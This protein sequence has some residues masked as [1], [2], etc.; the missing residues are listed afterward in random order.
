MRII[1]KRMQYFAS[2][3]G[4]YR[5]S[6]TSPWACQHRRRKKLTYFYISS[7]PT[8]H[9]TVA[10]FFIEKG[11]KQAIRQLCRLLEWF[12]ICRACFVTKFLQENEQ[13]DLR[14]W[15]EK[16]LTS[17]KTC[18]AVDLIWEV[19]R[20]CMQKKL[21][22]WSTRSWLYPFTAKQIERS[23][24][25]FHVFQTN[26]RSIKISIKN[27]CER[28]CNFAVW[29]SEMMMV[30]L[31]IAFTQQIKWVPR[32]AMSLH[33]HHHS[34]AVNMYVTGGIAL[35][36]QPPMAQVG[37]EK[38][39]RNSISFPH[40]ILS[41]SWVLNMNRPVPVVFHLSLIFVFISHT[42]NNTTHSQVSEAPQ[43]P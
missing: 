38:S 8:A 7:F 32:P 30:S 17:W 37:R 6:T 13:R 27:R 21:E 20:V 19:A 35:V 41:S 23:W 15:K 31:Q 33:H 10:S 4:S 11:R 3:R 36:R 22:K 39:G 24:N 43:L 25:V 40:H 2:L 9:T 26:F 1:R 34:P 28:K 5:S 29:W 16:S 14:K 18:G 12:I 42:L